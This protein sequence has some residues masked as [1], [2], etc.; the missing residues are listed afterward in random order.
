[1]PRLW[2]TRAR[3]AVASS[4]NSGLAS[5]GAAAD[6]KFPNVPPEN[7][8]APC[9][10]KGWI[11][12]ELADQEGQPVANEAYHVVTSDGSV[13]DGVLD[14]HGFA[15]IGGIPEGACKVSFPSVHGREWKLS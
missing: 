13:H 7:L 8:A 12:I 10:K 14:D 2:K 15:R 1:M 5:S 3:S 9:P 6:Q 11:A 4:S